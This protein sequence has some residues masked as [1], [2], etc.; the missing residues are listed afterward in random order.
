M[1]F[2]FIPQATAQSEVVETVSYT[3]QPNDTLWDYASRITPAGADVYDTIAQIK[4]IN[5]LDSDQLTAG[6]TLL[7][8]EA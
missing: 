1:A 5:H 7:V 6:Q 2:I 8:P 4:R 3:V